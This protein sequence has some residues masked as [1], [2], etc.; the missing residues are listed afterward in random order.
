M[1]MGVGS[2]K[3]T[4]TEKRLRGQA[5]VEYLM[6]YG[7]ALLVL[8]IVVGL[9]YTSIG[10]PAAFVSE[11]CNLGPKLPCNHFILSESG[12]TKLSIGMDN[13]FS[14]RIGISAVT[15]KNSKDEIFTVTSGATAQLASGENATIQAELPSEIGKGSLGNFKVQIEYYS[16]APEVNPDCNL[17][18]P[19]SSARHTISGRIRGISN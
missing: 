3:S 6:T 1:K 13:G 9:I 2:G 16:C 4:F 17:P 15:I 10:N 14:Y 5:A 19:G 18:S 8:A 12:K 7:W 11:E